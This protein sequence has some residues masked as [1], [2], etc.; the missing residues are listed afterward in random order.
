[1]IAPLG[2]VELIGTAPLGY[3]IFANF[4]ASPLAVLRS[5]S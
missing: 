4:P 5:N 3:L 1:V 2:Y